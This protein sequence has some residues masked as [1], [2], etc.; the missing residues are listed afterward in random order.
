MIVSLSR[1]TEI[2]HSMKMC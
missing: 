2:K 1:T